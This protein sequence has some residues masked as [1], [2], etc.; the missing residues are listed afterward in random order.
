MSVIVSQCLVMLAVVNGVVTSVSCFLL[1]L[2]DTYVECDSY[3]GMHV[4]G[5]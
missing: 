4:P 5:I 3:L 1:L 2:L